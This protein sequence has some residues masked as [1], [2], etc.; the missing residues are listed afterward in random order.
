VALL[1]IEPPENHKE[2]LKAV[3]SWGQINL[4]EKQAEVFRYEINRV[5][6]R[7]LKESGKNQG[8]NF[9]YKMIV[10]EEHE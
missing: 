2:E 8:K 10:I 4:S 5:L 1:K 6:E 7:Y 3:N 9:L